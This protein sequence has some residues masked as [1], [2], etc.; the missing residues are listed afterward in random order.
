MVP[1][2]SSIAGAGPSLVLREVRGVA[3]DI[4]ILPGDGLTLLA[5]DTPLPGMKWRL[6]ATFASG[7]IVSVALLV[8]GLVAFPDHIAAFLDGTDT[9]LTPATSLVIVNAL[10]VFTSVVPMP[11]ASDITSCRNDFTQIVLLPWMKPKALENLVKAARGATLVRML[12]LRKYQ[13]AY[14]EGRRQLALDPGNWSV[15]VQLA[16]MLIFSRRH[17]EAAVEYDI[18][19]ADPAIRGEGVPPLLAAMVKNNFA[20]ANLLVGGSEALEAAELASSKAFAT[21]PK[22]PSIVGTRGAVLIA[23][24]NVEAG[25]PLIERAL[26]LH[27]DAHARASCYACLALAAAELGRRDEARRLLERVS[28]LDRDC[29]LASR[30]EL[31]LSLAA[32]PA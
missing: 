8:L 7:P 1:H 25:R 16:D 24:G 13:A 27:R 3:I 17:A 26:K 2:R 32:A 20:W 11:R 19:W 30:V 6:L 23:T 31:K 5:S 28:K 14:D 21:A 18:L 9:W 29:E 10:L 12:L 4:G 15:R 22:N